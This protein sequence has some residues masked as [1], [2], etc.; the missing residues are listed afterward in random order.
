MLWAVIG[1]MMPMLLNLE[2]ENRNTMRQHQSR[3][4]ALAMAQDIGASG[5]EFLAAVVAGW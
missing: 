1:I 2:S 4:A 5:R 3:A